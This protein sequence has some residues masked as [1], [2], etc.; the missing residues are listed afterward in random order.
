M[1]NIQ[2]TSKEYILL[3]GYRRYNAVKKLG[4]KKVSATVYNEDKVIII[5]LDDIDL[6]DNSRKDEKSNEIIELMESIKQNGLIQPI[7]VARSK[8]LT[9]ED[10]IALNLT[11]NIQRKN[12]TPIEVSIRLKRLLKLG[13]SPGEVAVRLGLAKSSVLKLL[14]LSKVFNEDDLKDVE[15][16]GR[17]TAASQ[18]GK[19]SYSTANKVA[20]ARITHKQQRELLEVVKQKGMSMQNTDI[21]VR[22]I[23]YGMTAKQAV[24]EADKFALFSSSIAYNKEVMENMLKKYELKYTSA[25]VIGMLTGRI[26]LETKLFYFARDIK[27]FGQ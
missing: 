26:P 11:E 5:D 20:G 18:K 4:W 22:L 14:R 15:F 2:K 3:A 23:N 16:S 13:L 17:G 1:S 21:V 24:K 8:D 27:N 10:F 7:V 6:G 9:E 12:L 25:V 19:V